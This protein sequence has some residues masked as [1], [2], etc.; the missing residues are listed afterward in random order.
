MARNGHPKP[1]RYCPRQVAS[2]IDGP[3][4][5]ANPINR[6]VQLISRLL[7]TIKK[8]PGP[9]AAIISNNAM[10]KAPLGFCPN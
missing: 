9:M 2:A 10:A 6:T 8:S 4:V 5:L 1:L 7:G 3:G